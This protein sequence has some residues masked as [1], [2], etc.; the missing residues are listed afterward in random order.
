MLFNIWAKEDMGSEACKATPPGL[1]LLHM[2]GDRRNTS[3]AKIAK[4]TTKYYGDVFALEMQE[5]DEDTGYAISL[6][7]LSRQACDLRE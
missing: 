3:E 1:T 7:E 2:V 6:E 5:P 4:H